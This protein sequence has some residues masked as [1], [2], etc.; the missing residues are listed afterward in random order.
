MRILVK[1]PNKKDDTQ[2][3]DPQEIMAEIKSLDTDSQDI[4]SKLEKLV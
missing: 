1:N 4:L 3:R 2:L